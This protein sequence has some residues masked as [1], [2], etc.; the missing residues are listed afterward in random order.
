MRQRSELIGK[1]VFSDAPDQPMFFVCPLIRENVEKLDP[2]DGTVSKYM[3]LPQTSGL[4]G[5][6]A[7]GDL[8]AVGAGVGV[9]ATFLA[10]RT[11]RTHPAAFQRTTRR[12][13]GSAGHGQF[14]AGVVSRGRTIS[15]AWITAVS[16]ATTRRPS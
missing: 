3:N 11:V 5:R 9:W 10:V 12:R 13:R 7:R 8:M 6:H 4:I 15:S 1:H 2:S 16:F 14:G